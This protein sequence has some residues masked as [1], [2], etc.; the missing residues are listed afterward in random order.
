MTEVR[1]SKVNKKSTGKSSVG[2]RC[3]Q[4]K[5]KGQI[6]GLADPKRRA[7]DAAEEKPKKEVIIS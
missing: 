3:G 1:E 6:I 5:A 4:Q 2:K 7:Q